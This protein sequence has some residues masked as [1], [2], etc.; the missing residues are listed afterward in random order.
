MFLTK[1]SIIRIALMAGAYFVLGTACIILAIICAALQ[2]ESKILYLG[3]LLYPFCPLIAWWGV[4]TEGK[5]K[6][7]A[8][9]NRLVMN[10]LDPDEFLA[11]YHEL[12]SSP[13]LVICKPSMDVLQFVV[14]AYDSLDDRESCIAAVDDM[15]AQAP[16]KKKIFA[17]INKASVLFSYG[18]LEEAEALFTEIRA[19]KKDLVCTNLTDVVL[20]S[21]RA[22]AMGDDKTAEDYNLKLLEQKFPKINPLTALVAHFSLGKIYERQQNTQKAILHYQYCAEHG[23]KTAM[24]SAAKAALERLQ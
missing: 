6:W 15:I 14:I 10:E 12:I 19:A 16:E 1:K 8:L 24:Q 23:G 9:A 20:K 7:I 17:M 4:Y 18:R 2:Q 5:A 21:D 22:L 11:R 3:I 13:D